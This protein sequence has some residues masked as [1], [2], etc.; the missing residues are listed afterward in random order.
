MCVLRRLLGVLYKA[1][2]Y[3]V[4]DY[5][6]FHDHCVICVLETF[7]GKRSGQNEEID[8]EKNI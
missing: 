4:L 5:S 2:R 8:G 7:R 1:V 6:L 3:D